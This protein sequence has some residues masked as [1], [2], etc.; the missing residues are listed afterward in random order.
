MEENEVK[1]KKFTVQYGL[2]GGLVGVVFG[3]MLFSMDLHY[4]RSA[5]IQGIQFGILGVFVVIG[6]LQFK[7]ANGS[8]LTIK[9]ALKIGAGIG[10]IAALIGTVYF[11]IL[12]N[13]IEPDYLEKAGEISKVQAFEDNPRL[14]QEQWDQGMEIQKKFFPIL[15]AIGL[16]MS[17]LFG[18]VI[19]LI[20]GLIA[21]KDK[22]SY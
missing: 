21:K 19:G 12:S 8:Y 6:I 11:L 13:V 14:T 17:A 2:L 20:T 3:I 4:D 16:I 1:T 18:L 22:A 10:L 15:L 5:A 7:K 9:Q